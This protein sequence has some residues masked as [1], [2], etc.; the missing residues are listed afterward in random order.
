M[1]AL[2]YASSAMVF[3]AEKSISGWK[4]LFMKFVY[5]NCGARDEL[6]NLRVRTPCI[7]DYPLSKTERK[8]DGPG[9]SLG[10]SERASPRS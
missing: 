6:D 8:R 4:T 1:P 9:G 3:G 7:A 10:L 5:R 2:L